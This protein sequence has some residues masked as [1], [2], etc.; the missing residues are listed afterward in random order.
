MVKFKIID[1][2]LAAARDAGYQQ[3]TVTAVATISSAL[4]IAAGKGQKVFTVNISLSYDPADL[5]LEGPKWDAYQSG[6]AQGLAEND[7]MA[8]EYAI[9]LNT[10][11]SVST[12]MDL[13]FSF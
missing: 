2:A 1:T 4:V 12:S 13:N 11:D 3:V 7:I 9:V 10:S 8:N 6:V 5:R